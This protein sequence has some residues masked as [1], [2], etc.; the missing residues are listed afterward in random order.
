MAKDLSEKQRQWAKEYSHQR[1]RIGQAIRRARAKG[2]DIKI[3]DI[4]KERPKEFSEGY[5]DYLKN[6][7][8]EKLRT[9]ATHWANKEKTAEELFEEARRIEDKRAL[10][11]LEQDEEF[12][13]AFSYGSLAWQELTSRIDELS[14]LSDDIRDYVMFILNEEISSYGLDAV[15]GNIGAM[16]EELVTETERVLRYATKDTYKVTQVMKLIEV[17]TGTLMTS[18]QTKNL[19]SLFDSTVP[20]DD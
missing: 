17:I 20:M 14:F 11:K 18:E 16:P 2:Y 1:R 13:E 8:P 3:E 15:M 9:K 10:T 7:S 6:L 4:I 5:I 12:S 19:T